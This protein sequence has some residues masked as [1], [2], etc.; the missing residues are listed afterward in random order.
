LAD[1]GDRSS[2]HLNLL[3][4]TGTARPFRRP[5]SALPACR[6]QCGM[7]RTLIGA[8]KIP[9]VG[10]REPNARNAPDIRHEARGAGLGRGT[11]PSVAL[12][13]RRRLQITFLVTAVLVLV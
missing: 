8:G 11:A 6:Y 7:V 9:P 12:V 2:H 1:G 13:E 10:E 5:R 4:P 3:C